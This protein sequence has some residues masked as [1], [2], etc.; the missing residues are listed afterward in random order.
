MAEVIEKDADRDHYMNAE[1]A[2]SYGVVDEILTKT[3]VT[4]DEDEDE[5]EE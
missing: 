4:E 3:P 5:D 1:E 2:K